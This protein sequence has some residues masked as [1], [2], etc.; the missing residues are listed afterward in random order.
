MRDRRAT[1]G[2]FAGVDYTEGIVAGVFS[3]CACLGEVNCGYIVDMT[4]GG[5]GVDAVYD[6]V[7]V[8]RWVA[9]LGF[10]VNGYLHASGGLLSFCNTRGGIWGI[11]FM[12]YCLH[13]VAVLYVRPALVVFEEAVAVF[14]AV[15]VAL[16]FEDVAILEVVVFEEVELFEDV[17]LR[18]YSC[19]SFSVVDASNLFPFRRKR[20]PKSILPLEEVEDVFN[21]GAVVFVEAV[22]ILVEVLVVAVVLVVVFVVVLVQ[23]LGVFSGEVFAVV[24]ATVAVVFLAEVFAVDLAIVFAVVFAVVLAVVFDVV[25]GVVFASVAALRWICWILRPAGFCAAARLSEPSSVPFA[26]DDVTSSGSA[27]SN[28]SNVF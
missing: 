21:A 14:G 9:A 5:G 23:V 19:C 24:F 11:Y 13:T 16:D 28:P 7:S 3:R 1:R 20:F 8:G 6:A 4:V 26:S 2:V 17:V 12:L 25:F 22:G 27:K 10:N 18:F 15:E